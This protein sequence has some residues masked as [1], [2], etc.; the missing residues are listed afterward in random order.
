MKI[1]RPLIALWIGLLPAGCEYFEVHPYDTDVQEMTGINAANMLRIESALE[2]RTSCRFAVISD[3]QGFY[4][5]TE[6]AVAALNAR[7]DLDFVV[8]CGDLSDF[9]LK[10][11]FQFQRDILNR[12]TVPYVALIG[13]HDC[14][15]TGQEVFEKIFGSVNFAFTAGDTRFICLNTN[16]MEYDYATPVPDFDFMERELTRLPAETTRVVWVMHVQPG[17]FQFNNNVSKAFEYYITRAP[18][19][20]FC[21]Y[22]HGHTLRTDDLFDDGILW[23]QCPSAD[24]R[25]YLL[26]TLNENG[27]TYEAIPF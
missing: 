16:A 17:D 15:A 5:E 7:G 23:Y 13:N 4:D 8:H 22:G 10:K 19:Q 25:T 21:L 14:L 12:L 3:T 24:K 9:G 27:Y 18:G 20:P 2:G 1:L 26:F 6:E 11:E